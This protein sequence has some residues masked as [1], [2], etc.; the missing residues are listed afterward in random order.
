MDINFLDI[1]T[2]VIGV[3]S[4]G[5]NHA[6]IL[7]DISN[8]IGVA[9][10]NEEQ[11]KRVAGNLGVK[12]YKDYNTMLEDVDAVSIVVPTNMHRLIADDV[13]DKGLHLLVE[14]PLSRTV[15]DAQAIT[16][17]AKEKNIV[18][19]VGHIERFNPVVQYVKKALSEKKWGDLISISAR[20]VSPYPARISDVGVIFDLSIHD[21]DILCYLC[22]S[23][24][25][26]IYCSGGTFKSVKHEDHVSIVVNF[27]S[28]ITGL[29]ETSWLTPMKIRAL[30]LTCST[31]YIEVDYIQQ[32]I[33]IS[34]S[35]FLEINYENLYSSPIE[36]KKQKIILPKI[37]PLKTE[38][39]D[40]LYSIKSG[41]NPL[42]TGL[43]GVKAV[44]MAQEA[45]D[46]L[47][48]NNK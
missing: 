19:S 45:L 26:S 35:N 11:G 14:K 43:D 8:L 1:R 4:M 42:V 34:E 16:E 39:I 22:D 18:L 10:T 20:R 9:D 3:G 5:Q 12:W 37:E 2:G 48:Y 24:P 30:T 38:L 36:F 29:C 44:K 33:E 25:K 17:H 46:S 6:R 7:N 31:H 23:T 47:I 41:K 28:G 15:K 27:D 13:I 21:L 32:S 40:F